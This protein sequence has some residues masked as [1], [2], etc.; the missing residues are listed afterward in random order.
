MRR[1]LSTV[2]VLTVVAFPIAITR[3]VGAGPVAPDGR[4]AYSS[5]ADGDWDIWTVAADGSDGVNL[6]SVD[7]PASGWSDTQPSWSPDG[8]RIVFVSDR[9]GGD[10][11]IY[12]MG[13]DG[14]G[15]APITDNDDPDSAPDWSSDGSRI[16]FTSE[17]ASAGQDDSDIFAVD[18]DGAHE[19]DLT[20][21]FENEPGQF[22][23]LDKDPDWSPIDDR[24]VFASARIVAG[25][26]D[27]AYW[28]I[29]TM[30]SD[31]SD[32]VVVSDPNDPGN[33]PFPDDIPNFDEMPEWSPDGA[34]IAFATHQ[35]PEQQWDIQLVRSDGTQQ[36]N[37]LP[38]QAV[39]DLGPA[40]SPDGL[41][42]VFASG[43]DGSGSTTLYSLDVS[44]IVGSSAARAA[45]AQP[46]PIGSGSGVDPDQFGRMPCTITGTD[47]IERLHGTAQRDVIC[48]KGGDDVID[49][50]G[51]PDVIYSGAGGDRVM[52]RGGNDIL[53]G[54]TG[55]D[56][57]SGGIGIDTCADGSTT[58]ISGCE[59]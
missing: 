48:G 35:Q 16:V 57:L 1:W 56:N 31:G 7:E 59:W 12:V 5:D 10:T 38:D 13:R 4:I 3:P 40:W 36:T 24:I 21:P 44:G 54:G 39:D 32:Q 18:A 43:R 8:T 30:R 20:T 14:A 9:V 42:I 47:W 45:A 26:P 52:G 37:V 33:D 22:Q 51:G 49:G 58:S 55:A 15:L 19:Q 17:R 29:V 2:I 25:S 46:A 53:V 27:G 6:T 34:W 50:R 23:W 28:R 11:D 41:T